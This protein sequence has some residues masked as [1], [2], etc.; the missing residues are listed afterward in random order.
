MAKNSAQPLNLDDI[1]EDGI[2]DLDQSGEDALN[3]PIDFEK[4]KGFVLLE[5]GEYQFRVE[6]A[7]AELSKTSSQPVAKVRLT[8]IDGPGE[9]EGNMVFQDISLSDG[10]MRRSKALLIGMGLPSTTNL[11]PVQICAE[12]KGLEFWGVMDVERSDG[13]NERTN[14]AYDPR[15]K[16]VSASQ[17]PTM[18]E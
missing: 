1:G 18:S 4:V 2:D 9:T 7:K 5:P 17:T 3:R 12:L 13:I 6:H 11:S 14:R 15:N 16:L 10:G 8:V